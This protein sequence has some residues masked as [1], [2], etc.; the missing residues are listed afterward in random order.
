MDPRNSYKFAIIKYNYVWQ[1]TFHIFKV[2]FII[3]GDS[4]L[5]GR[6]YKMYVFPS[7]AEKE[8]SNG[9]ILHKTVH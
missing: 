8:V 3:R 9:S 5:W 4:I 2:Y 1:A 7:G 6:K